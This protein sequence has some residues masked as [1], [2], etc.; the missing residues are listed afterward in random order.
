MSAIEPREIRWDT[1]HIKGAALTVELTGSASKP[2]KARFEQVLALLGSAHSSWGATRVVKDA[3]NVEDVEQGSESGLRHFLES[4]VLQANADPEA[5]VVAQAHE[6][7]D[8]KGE[9][10]PDERMTRT[11]RSFATGHSASQE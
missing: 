3:I 8:G 7:I 11:F 10:D 1:A 9:L 4:V 2:W 5:D 6:R